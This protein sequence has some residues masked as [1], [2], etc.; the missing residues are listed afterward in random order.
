MWVEKNPL[1]PDF[2]GE[3]PC[4]ICYD[5]ADDNGVRMPG[6]EK[7][8]LDLIG[9]VEIS[10]GER[11]Q[12]MKLAEKIH[13]EG[14]PVSEPIV[15]APAGKVF[16]IGMSPTE[17]TRLMMRQFR[18]ATPPKVAPVCLDHME[19]IEEVVDRQIADDKAKVSDAE[20]QQR[21]NNEMNRLIDQRLSGRVPAGVI[22]D[23]M[24][25]P[26]LA[27]VPPS[28]VEMVLADRKTMVPPQEIRYLWE[29]D[30]ARQPV[31]TFNYISPDL[32]WKW[33]F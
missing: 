18:P 12:L 9:R 31:A 15:P 19:D 8:A 17:R 32:D 3:P 13:V 27:G 16:D 11:V 4:S 26:E 28:F 20:A 7:F 25:C 10:E 30:K 6:M 2:C 22:R 21:M 29:S 1:P 33:K 23:Y 5:W 14:L 24:G